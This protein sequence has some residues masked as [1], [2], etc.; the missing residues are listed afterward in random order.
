MWGKGGGIVFSECGRNLR[1]LRVRRHLTFIALDGMMR[2][3]T[4]SKGQGSMHNLLQG[5]LEYD[6]FC[7]LEDSQG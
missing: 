5:Y 4:M 3:F 6:E 2:M 7:F 1:T